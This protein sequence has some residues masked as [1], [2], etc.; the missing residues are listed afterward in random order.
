MRTLITGQWKR[1]QPVKETQRG[2]LRVNLLIPRSPSSSLVSPSRAPPPATRHPP[3]LGQNKFLL[4][5]LTVAAWRTRNKVMNAVRVESIIHLFVFHLKDH[6]C[7]SMT[8]AP[9]SQSN[10]WA[11]S[12]DF[13]F[14][15]LF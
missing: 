1:L 4:P 6:L 14:K 5:A 3:P 8:A 2:C 7:I 15:F 11:T 12:G 9:T 13:F 10:F